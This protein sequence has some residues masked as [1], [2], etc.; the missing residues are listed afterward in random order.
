MRLASLRN[1]KRDGQL[2]VVSRERGDRAAQGDRRPGTQAGQEASKG[3]AA[4][5]DLLHARRGQE[6]REVDHGERRPDL[7]DPFEA[8]RPAE[9]SDDRVSV[10]KLRDEDALVAPADALWKSSYLGLAVWEDA[11]VQADLVDP[12]RVRG[13][14]RRVSKKAQRPAENRPQIEIVALGTDIADDAVPF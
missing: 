10:A 13:R 8:D 1:G 5:A 4:K 11:M 2:V 14:K 7:G 9:E 6:A 3:V 12:P